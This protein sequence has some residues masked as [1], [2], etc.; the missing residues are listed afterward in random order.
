LSISAQG[1]GS[2]DTYKGF[3]GGL[4]ENESN[5]V[6]TDHGAT[7]NSFAAKIK[8]INGK[9]V[10]L[11]LGMSNAADE[12]GMFIRNYAQNPQINSAVAIVNGAFPSVG[13]CALSVPS[14]L[15]HDACGGSAP[16]PFDHVLTYALKPARLTEDQ[17]QVIW[18]KEADAMSQQLPWPPS[19]PTNTRCTNPKDTYSCAD[20]YIY[21]ML[22]GSMVRAAKVRYRNLQMVFISSRIYGG[23]N[24]IS[25][26]H[27]PY[28][29]E[30]AFSVKWAIQAQI[31][32]AD[33]HGSPD[34]IAGNLSYSVAPWLAW[35]PYLWA[36]GDI[37]RLDGLVWCNGQSGRPC[38]GEVDFQSDGLHPNTNGQA[39]VA[40]ML[41][42]FFLTSP[43][44]SWFK[45]Q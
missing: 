39:K 42:N 41:M 27:E 3:E 14:G 2:S 32:Q 45:A 17:V 7:G 4:Y 20:A 23:Y 6:P 25:K 19:L 13:P 28:A 1:S 21:E 33:R 29:Y 35:G 30:Y 36:D 38:Y 26:N 34:G 9:I 16:N 5:V 37:P 24:Q 44:T 43:Y 11:S 15:P 8:P 18:L 31:N 22:I 12:F 40:S 10:I